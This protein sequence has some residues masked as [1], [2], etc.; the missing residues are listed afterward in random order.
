MHDLARRLLLIAQD[1]LESRGGMKQFASFELDAA[2]QCLWHAGRQIAL[3]PKPFAVLKYLV[4]NPG[5]LV[6]HDELMEALWPETYVQPQVLRTY[7]LDLRKVLGDDAGQPRFIQTLPK[8]GYCFVAAVTESH[9]SHLREGHASAPVPQ[10]APPAAFAVNT[11]AGRDAEFE[12]LHTL[13]E[14]AAA[15]QRQV[16]FLT[17]EAGIGKTALVEAF[18]RLQASAFSFVVAQGQCVEGLGKREAYYPIMEALHH[19]CASRYGERACAVLARVAPEWLSRLGRDASQ[20]V[21]AARRRQEPSAGDLC[22]ALEELSSDQ[23]LLLLLEDLH[24]ADESS[25]ALLSALARRRAPARLLVVATYS[26]RSASADHPLKAILQDLLVHRQCAE[27]ALQPLSR[28]AVQQ[29]ISG[30]LQQEQ[31][32]PGLAAFVHRHSEGNPLFV[33]ALLDH[34]VAERFLVQ[35]GDG[36]HRRWEQRAPYQEMEAGVPD[37][38]AKSIELEIERLAPD[39]QRLLEAAS[40]MAVAF[41]AWAVAAALDLDVAHAEELCQDL[42]RRLHFV[43]RAGEE[44]LPDGTRSAF[45][46]FA[47]GLYREVLYQRQAPAARATRHVRI[48]QR[49]GQVFAGREAIVAREMALHYEA[50][51]RWHGAASAL[52]EAAR[53]ACSRNACAEAAELLAHA[54]RLADNLA[55]PERTTLRRQIEADLSQLCQSAS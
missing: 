19:L 14:R 17:G 5:R 53:R 8:R 42:A 50:A 35:K 4:D 34:L 28:Q 25:L 51:G 12:R 38:L 21:D 33:T 44:D 24:W 37:G 39:Q 20:P 47:H 13:A 15:G 54:R 32:P 10:A 27:L 43:D 41:P 49:V 52:R 45:Y 11:L 48:A 1:G 23:P 6:T 26:P 55:D 18:A 22:S 46:V 29:L 30:Q 40:L 7:V 36:A 31:L 2:N 3:P 9:S 16:V